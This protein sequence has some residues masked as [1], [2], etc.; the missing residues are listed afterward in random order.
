MKADGLAAGKGVVV[1]REREE[2]LE[3]LHACMRARAFDSAGD[4]VLV[5]EYVEGREV[6]VFAFCDGEHLSPLVAACDYKRLLDGDEG[7]N[8]GGMGSYS[9]P[10][11]WDAGATGPC[12]Q[13]NNDPCS[14]GIKTPVHTLPGSALRRTDAY[15][16]GPKGP[17]VQLPP[18][19]PRSP[20]RS[21]PPEDRSARCDHCFHRGQ[22]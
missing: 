22:D 14:S 10:E 1:C 13:R 6:S 21:T 7:P 3:A 20:G 12:Q 8:T 15:R 2:A 11:F 17:R 5:E 16:P 9:P 18:G 4:T 19:R